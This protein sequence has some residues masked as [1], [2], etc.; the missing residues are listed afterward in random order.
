MRLQKKYTHSAQQEPQMLNTVCMYTYVDIF[1]QSEISKKKLRIWAN[2]SQKRK[3]AFATEVLNKLKNAVTFEY[4][5]WV[6][7]K[8][9]YMY[10]NNLLLKINTFKIS[11]QIKLPYLKR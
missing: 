3:S 1:L 5:K 7:S 11:K 6:I 8:N 10:L 4:A 9:L 2:W